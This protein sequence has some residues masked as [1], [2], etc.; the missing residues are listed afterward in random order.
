M[1]SRNTERGFTLVELMVGVVVA[2]A[3]TAVVIPQFAKQSGRVRYDSEVHA[4]FSELTQREEAMKLDSGAFLA[5]AECLSAPD[6]NGQDVTSA[7]LTTG[8]AWATLGVRAPQSKIR[9]TYQIST[10]CAGDSATVPAGVTFDGGAS[11]W[12]YVVASCGTGADAVTYFTGSTDSRIQKVGGAPSYTA[13]TGCSGVAK[14]MVA[15]VGPAATSGSTGTGTGTGTSTGTGTTGTG[16]GGSTGGTTTGTTTTT[17]STTG[18]TGTGAAG[19]GTT[20]TTT[21]GTTTGGTTSGGTT[22]T[23]GTTT[24][25][26]GTTTTG[27]SG[28]GGGST[29]VCKK[30][31]CKKI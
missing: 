10:G 20:S 11:S 21:T 6:P 19:T 7:C 1:K 18:T 16:T 4:V 24:T 13:S 2:G 23:T 26:S 9:C 28:G 12:Y 27:T 15:E 31:K 5:A 14:V 8:S 30:G 17:G 3:L 22:S 25:G 29:V